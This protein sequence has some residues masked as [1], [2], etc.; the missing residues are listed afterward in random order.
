MKSYTSKHFWKAYKRL[1]ESTRRQARQAYKV[2]EEDPAHPSLHFKKAYTSEP[3][4]SVRISLDFRALGRRDGE[5]II[6]FWIG[7]HD[8]YDQLIRQL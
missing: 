5:G 7:P 2:F 6:W 8:E 4:Y 3:I 1:D